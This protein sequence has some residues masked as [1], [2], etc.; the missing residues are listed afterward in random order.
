MCGSAHIP[1]VTIILTQTLTVV[2]VISTSVICSLPTAHLQIH[3]FAIRILLLPVMFNG[4]RALFVCYPAFAEYFIYLQT[5][6]HALAMLIMKLLIISLIHN[7]V[8]I[9]LSKEH[10]L[11]VFSSALSSHHR[12]CHMQLSRYHLFQQ[13]FLSKIRQKMSCRTVMQIKI[14]E[15]EFYIIK[16]YLS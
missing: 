11:L 7:V 15:C 5:S 16:A 2:K 12:C 8:V 4:S 1:L 14:L 3:T 9:V 6:A 10:D 13:S